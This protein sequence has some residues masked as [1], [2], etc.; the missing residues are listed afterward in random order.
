MQ[1]PLLDLDQLESFTG[2]GYDD[3]LDLL[4]DIIHDVPDHL[5]SIRA[6]IHAGNSADFSSRLHS[7]RGMISYFGCIS[8]TD[9]L[10]GMEHHPIVA[11]DQA[12]TIHAE[13]QDLWERSFAAIKDWEKS[14]P[15]FVPS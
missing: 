9:R 3:Y 2:I 1:P 4:G 11:P 5:E 15:A 7:L 8:L 13:L 6:S 14:V 12:A 10:A